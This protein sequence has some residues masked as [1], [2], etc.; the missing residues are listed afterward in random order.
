MTQVELAQRS[1][2][3]GVGVAMLLA[4]AALWSLNGLV[5]KLAGADPIA[6]AGLRS[7]I[8]AGFVLLFL[9]FFSGGRP[10]FGPM[11]GCVLFHTLMVGFFIAAITWGR[12]ASGVILQYTG[13]AWVALIAWGLQGQRIGRRTVIAVV[14]TIIGVVAMLIV[15][16][17]REKTFDPIGPTCGLLAGIAFGALVV[18]LEKVDRDAG[19]ANPLMIIFINNAGTAALLVPLAYVSDRLH[20]SAGQLGLIA[21]CGIVQHALP[22]LLFQLGLR[23]VRP[24]EASLLILLEPLLSPTWVAIFI[25]EYPSVWDFAGGAA[26]FAALILEATK[27]NSSPPANFAAD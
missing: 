22:Y 26:I 23:R 18:M 1:S 11:L 8:A 5:V 21:F 3:R 9:P 15:P 6:F 12:A 7:A 14:L 20:L 25:G 2:R 13:P 19:G 24:V 10:A 17:L 27:K 4:C 16:L